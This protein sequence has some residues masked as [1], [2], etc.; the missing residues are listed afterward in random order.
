VTTIALKEPIKFGT[1]TITEFVLRPPKAKDFRKFPATPT[2][3]DMLDLAGQLAGQPKQVIDEI[4]IEDMMRVLEEIG[5]F[6]QR[7][8]ETGLDP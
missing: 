7:G 8:P 1:E 2:T 6:L 5:V 3:G 4:G